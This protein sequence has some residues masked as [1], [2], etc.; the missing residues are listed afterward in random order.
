MSQFGIGL[1]LAGPPALRQNAARYGPLARDY[2][3][4]VE[5]GGG[6]VVD[7]HFTN[8]LLVEL[9]QM[10]I[11]DDA[12]CIV[13]PRL[14]NTLRPDSGDLFVSKA[15]DASPQQGHFEQEAEVN[16]PKLEGND[17][18]FAGDKWLP[19]DSLAGQALSEATQAA[20]WEVM[21]S[22][23]TGS[24]V[25]MTYR[26]INGDSR[27]DQNSQSGPRWRYFARNS[28][29]DTDSFDLA[30]A[31]MPED[32]NY[33]I[34]G[35]R[36][37]GTSQIAQRESTIIGTRPRDIGQFAGGQGAAVIGAREDGDRWHFNDLYRLCIV[38]ESDPGKAAWDALSDFVK[39]KYP[40]MP[41][42]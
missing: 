7:Q 24:I 34:G 36:W 30:T 1:G 19:G 37:D 9:E 32:G 5:S 39:A 27:F 16:Q 3:A 35:Q 28:S 23:D 17:W 10:G 14:G 33:F 25:R 41:T 40:T 2:F 15:W 38:W 13:G 6:T 42:S 8:A 26:Y 22:L 31:D 18:N 29:E 11:Y 12:V 4:K 21:R 20:M